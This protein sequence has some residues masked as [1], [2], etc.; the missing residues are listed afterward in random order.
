MSEKRE[1]AE[2]SSGEDRLSLRADCENCFALCCVVPAFSASVDFA[3]DK[4]A[5]QACPNLRQDFRCGIHTRLRQQGFRGCTV[6][7]CFGAGQ[8]VSQVTFGGQDWRGSPRT[9]EQM[10]E[11]F[12]IMRDLH[13]LL[14][15]LT[16][17]LT[18]RP[19]R[20]LHGELGLALERT[21]RLTH[22][23][24]GALAELDVAAHRRDVNALLLRASE[25]V[26]AEVRHKKKDRRGA[27][28]IG[29]KLKG[30][31]LRGA[32]LRGAY[33]IGADLRGADLRMADLIGADF[34]GADLGGADLT[35]SIFLI[36]SQLDAAKGD[37]ATRLP[38]SLTRPAH[39]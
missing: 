36:Q 25:L 38:P 10:F 4:K 22:D 30:A 13:E 8:K 32:N 29:A 37:S 34:R 27:D 5:G 21:E 23:S 9:A 3:I 24:P 31:D 14:W 17:A 28:L 19:A 2:P 1:H 7:D 12:P 35:E 11:V 33:L 20:P 16:E 39:W 6:Y 15:Y 18:L 26:R